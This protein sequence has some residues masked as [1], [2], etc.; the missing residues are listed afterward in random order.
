MTINPRK[1][2]LKR[3][4]ME[5]TLSEEIYEA[6]KAPFKVFAGKNRLSS[7]VQ[8]VMQNEC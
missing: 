8:L 2:G 1:P 6:L 5:E 3:K 7:C 4:K